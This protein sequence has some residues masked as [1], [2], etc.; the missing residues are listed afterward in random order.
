[1]F[2]QMTK[3]LT[4]NRAVGRD[5]RARHPSRGNGWRRPGQVHSRV[6]GR[7]AVCHAESTHP[8]IRYVNEEELE[9]AIQSREKPLVIDFYATWCGPCVML[10]KELEQVAEQLGD[11]VDILKIDT[12]QNEGISNALQIQGLPT[13]IFVSTSNDKPALRT[14]GLLPAQSI[15][16]IV[17]NEL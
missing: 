9:V 11:K 13:L 10:S 15:I 8:S 12:D 7:R 3:V 14:E 16:E 4:A 2:M 6:G 1:M 5:E 17:L